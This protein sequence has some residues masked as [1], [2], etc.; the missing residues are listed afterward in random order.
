MLKMNDSVSFSCYYMGGDVSKGYSD[1]VILN[2]DK[3]VEEPNFQLDDTPKGHKIL[4]DRL[5][6]FFARRPHCI[7]H[8]G[9][10]S[11]G[12]YE[13]N[14]YNT[15]L[16]LGESTS[17]T[18]PR[19]NIKVIRLNPLGIKRYLESDLAR[20]KTDKISARAIAEYLISHG[21]KN[22]LQPTGLSNV[23][24]EILELYQASH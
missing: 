20:N 21:K 2:H 16:N 18:S 9:L 24:K 23:V 14:W 11:T 17:P 7:L 8:V 12:G 4:Q 1:F 10:E 3:E 15:F 22:Y 5:G 6:E 19:Y 13:S